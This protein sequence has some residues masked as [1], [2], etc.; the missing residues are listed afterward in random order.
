MKFHKYLGLIFLFLSITIFANPT[1]ST[2]VKKYSDNETYWGFKLGRFHYSGE[3][4][5]KDGVSGTFFNEHKISKYF[6][7]GN[8]LQIDKTIVSDEGVISLNGYLSYPLLVGNQK[9]FIKGG[10]GLATLG[11]INPIAMFEVEYI[12]FDF[13][14]LAFS[15]SIQKSFPQLPLIISIGILF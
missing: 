9:F 1:D 5:S 4:L 13:E 8:S 12:V 6:Y 10:L 15:V 7:F 3:Y 11:Y 14:K 2:R